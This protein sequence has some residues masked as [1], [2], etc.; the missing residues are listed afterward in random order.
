MHKLKKKNRN[1]MG[2]VSTIIVLT[3]VLAIVSF[4]LNKI[5][6]Q[7]Y[8]TSIENGVLADSLVSVK[9][10]LSVSGIKYMLGNTITNFQNFKPLALLIISLIGIGI[11]EKSGF[12]YVLFKPLKKV[13]FGVIVYF[14]ILISLFSTVLGE[15][16]YVFLIPF[17]G[18]MYKYLD[19]NPLLGI[20]ITFLSITF[21][22]GAGIIFNYNDYS[23]GILTE[24]AATLD[25]DPTYK[26]TLMSTMY[27]KI[28]ST[29][30]L[31]IIIYFVT[32]KFLIAK[33]PIK[34]RNEEELKVS[35]KGFFLAM[36]AGII[37]VLITIYMIIDVKLPGAGILLD[38]SKSIYIDKLF[39]DSAPFKEGLAI[40][41]S[42]IMM[43]SG[44]IYGKISGNIK[45]SNEYSLG[46]SKNFEN[47][48]QLFV[49][50]FFLSQL[51]AML[52]WS[53]LGVV[54]A[55]NLTSF[56]SNL[57]FS[58]VLLICTFF[59]IVII[60]SLLIPDTLTKWQITS[61]IVVP[62]FMR[63]NMAPSFTQF[64]FTTADALGKAFTPLFPYLIVTISF[65]QKYNNDENK[66]ITILSALK[67]MMPVILF[68][69]LFWIVF[70]SLWFLIGFP[71]G[72]GIYTA[73]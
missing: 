21:G 71:I 53:N 39:N 23:L 56:V 12:L 16:S 60:M 25:V 37:G 9:N 48:G 66:Q 41:I 52:D 62:L 7:G 44:F 2:P 61:P 14:T 43:A 19:R 1:L 11:C 5:G 40:I 54:V 50:M 47:L 59:I 64:I 34:A 24:T 46:L 70:I 20:M 4:I 38:S 32:D 17:I 28:V 68:V 22:Y 29:I 55:S 3:V 10:I 69:S 30:I 51:I 33:Y 65:L 58:G 26:Y 42:L 45:N 36:L 67:A 35:K 27:V 49:L 13:K 6:F 15:Y 72:P 63:A 57:Q 18:V 73:L 31:S 8:R